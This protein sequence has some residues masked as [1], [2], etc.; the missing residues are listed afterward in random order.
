MN[1]PTNPYA[2]PQSTLPEVL[3]DTPERQ[4]ALRHVRLALIILL[5]PGLYNF[6]CFD[7]QV[8][9][10][11]R[12]GMVSPIVILAR[13]VNAGGMIGVSVFVWF[14][15]LATLEVL[16]RVLFALFSRQATL[17]QWQAKL[18]G[19]LGRAGYFAAA[20]AVLWFVWVVAFYQLKWNFYAISWPIGILAHLLAAG[21]YVPLCFQWFQLERSAAA[22]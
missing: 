22:R 19:V 20:G 10:D 13:M 15:G 1:S 12:T 4:R 8:F 2:A 11:E 7:G 21:L 5:M 14:C 17:T 16:S 18:H 6:L 3:P 9:G